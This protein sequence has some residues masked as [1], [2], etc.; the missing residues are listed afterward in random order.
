MV[1]SSECFF[2]LLKKSKRRRFRAGL[3]HLQH[4][5]GFHPGMS[6]VIEFAVFFVLFFFVCANMVCVVCHYRNNSTYERRL[7]TSG[8]GDRYGGY[9]VILVAEIP[10]F[11]HGQ[12]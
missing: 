6:S 10:E 2:A 4:R 5:A 3:R 9:A 11:R 1:F 8:V 12:Y 7:M